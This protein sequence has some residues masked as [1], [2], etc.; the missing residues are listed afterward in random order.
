MNDEDKSHERTFEVPSEARAESK[1]LRFLVDK[2]YLA[3]IFIRIFEEGNEIFSAG[4]RLEDFGDIK[5]E[6][7]KKFIVEARRNTFAGNGVPSD[8]PRLRGS[9]ELEFRKAEWQYQDIYFTGKSNF[10]GQEI[11]YYNS[12]PVW[13]MTYFG[14]LIPEKETE[15]LK[16]ALFDL[17]EKCR[18][19]GKCS[20]AKKSFLYEDSGE[21]NLENFQGQEKISVSQKNIYKLNY[22]GGSVKK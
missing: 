6:E 2:N 11:V 12:S 21:G 15:F 4:K 8:N 20:L 9:T 7:L 10:I 19:G 14:N 16:R 17:S 13:S 5:P 1:Y 18:F 3:S 22:Q